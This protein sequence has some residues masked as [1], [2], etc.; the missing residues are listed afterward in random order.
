MTKFWKSWLWKVKIW[1]IFFFL[2]SF[3]N[4]PCEKDLMLNIS[5]R[6]CGRRTFDPDSRHSPILTQTDWLFWGG[7]R[8]GWISGY[9]EDKKVGQTT[10]K[11]DLP[12]VCKALK[13]PLPGSFGFLFSFTHICTLMIVK[14]TH[15]TWHIS[16]VSV[17][18]VPV[19]VTQDE[20]KGACFSTVA[21]A[22][23]V[24]LFCCSSSGA[25]VGR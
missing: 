1:G 6:Y 8:S 18:F 23:W 20:D 19:P 24:K 9:V 14:E 25:L 13:H 10:W 15:M 17:H 7:G 3:P 22:K 11:S 4:R 5:C 21:K 12:K 16:Y 2:L